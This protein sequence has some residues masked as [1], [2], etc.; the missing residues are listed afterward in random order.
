MRRICR[1]RLLQT[2]V[3][4]STK[5]Y[6]S[7]C[8]FTRLRHPIG[9]QFELYMVTFRDLNMLFLLLQSADCSVICT[10]RSLH[11]RCFQ[12]G[13]HCNHD[14][15]Y[16]QICFQEV[17]GTTI[18]QCYVKRL[19]VVFYPRAFVVTVFQETMKSY[20]WNSTGGIFRQK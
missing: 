5:R 19:E 10:S 20:I 14:G 11:G 8:C 12:F 15:H 7:P 9:N 1:I 6:L 17:N 18:H 2:S 13:P 3:V 4:S 16:Y